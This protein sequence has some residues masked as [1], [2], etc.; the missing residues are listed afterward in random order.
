MLALA[1]TALLYFAVN[2][3]S[4]GVSGQALPDESSDHDVL[5]ELRSF[6]GE[7]GGL[8]G[9]RIQEIH[10][11]VEPTWAS[12]PKTARGKLGTDGV[13]Y[14]LHRFFV[15]HGWNLDGL[16]RNLGARAGSTG[17]WLPDVFTRWSKG[18]LSER[19]ENVFE[20]EGFTIHEFVVLAAAVERIILDQGVAHMEAVYRSLDMPLDIRASTEEVDE[21]LD[22]YIISLVVG[23]IPR[24]NDTS[25]DPSKVY[26]GWSDMQMWLRDVRETVLHAD[27]GRINPFLPGVGVA[28][29]GMERLVRKVSE[30]FGRF[31]DTE[32]VQLKGALLDAEEGGT[33]RIR[34]SAFYE[35]AMTTKWQFAENSEYLH[36]IGTLDRTKRGEPRVIVPNY[37]A[38][39]ANCL[40]DDDFYSVCCISECEDVLLQI[41]RE[42]RAPQAA[43]ERIEYVV[44]NL[45]SSTVDAPR[46]LPQHMSK[47]LRELAAR[48]GGE[49]P[50]H[51]RMFAQWLHFAFPRECPY[52]HQAEWRRGSHPN[53]VMSPGNMKAYI[54]NARQNERGVQPSGSSS[55]RG[56]GG[57]GEKETEEE[58]VT[59]WVKEEESLYVSANAPNATQEFVTA[60]RQALLAI[61]GL[62]LAALTFFD[63]VR[64]CMGLDSCIGSAASFLALAI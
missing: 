4:H 59:E 2:F 33:G 35:Q 27:R 64:R 19:I 31:Q 47:R 39:A 22:F 14:A 36:Q 1:D 24:R 28:F 12:L 13:S 29:D 9:E 37:V 60:V 34:L 52:P 50:I 18:G 40:V 25:I 16:D 58:A 48:Y 55:G 26:P 20:A 56:G 32:C 61:V 30:E 54:N 11:I 53:T 21:A 57:G 5:Q 6:I 62:I 49:V 15:R 42:I 46:L 45:S 7:H 17:S 51:G 38:S 63:G 41:E 23:R 44:A 10:K 3:F 43:P 8:P